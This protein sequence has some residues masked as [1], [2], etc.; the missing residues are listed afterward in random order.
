M[1]KL[2]RLTR[3]AGGP[4]YM[5]PDYIVTISSEATGGSEKNSA[6]VTLVTSVDVGSVGGPPQGVQVQ[7]SVQEVVD[8][9]ERPPV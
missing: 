9:V 1:G 3:R 7:E 4:I 6:L 8:L 5:N 2:I